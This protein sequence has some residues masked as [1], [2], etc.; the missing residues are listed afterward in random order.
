M[1]DLVCCVSLCYLYFV[2]PGFYVL[3]F[4]PNESWLGCWFL[5]ML[6]GVLV[7][8]RYFQ[9]VCCV[10]VL[11]GQAQVVAALGFNYEPKDMLCG[12]I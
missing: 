1:V 9:D 10:F 7:C 4:F 11:V 6:H 8:P 2:L 3:Q 12:R 5:C